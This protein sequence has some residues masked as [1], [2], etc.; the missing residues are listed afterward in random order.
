LDKL[1][2]LIHRG[3]SEPLKRGRE[4]QRQTK[5]L[6]MYQLQEV[7]LTDRNKKYAPQKKLVF[8]KMKVITGGFSE[9]LFTP[10]VNQNVEK[11]KL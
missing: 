7:E 2:I 4:S 5:G 8:N 6:V 3:L 9:K 11:D 10:V 1:S